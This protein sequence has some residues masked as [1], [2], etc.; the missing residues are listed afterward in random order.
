MRPSRWLAQADAIQRVGRDALRN[1]HIYGDKAEIALASAEGSLTGRRVSV[2]DNICTSDMPTSCSSKMLLDYQSP[3]E[4][5]SVRLLRQAGAHI[6][7][8]TNCDEFGMGSANLYSVHGKVI[9]PHSQIGQERVAGGSSGGAAV[10]VAL[11]EVSI[12]LASDTGGSIRTP[13]AYCGVYGLKPSYGLISRWGVVPYADSLDTVGILGKDVEKVSAAFKVISQYDVQDPTSVTTEA[14]KRAGIVSQETIGNVGDA[15]GPLSGLRV[16]IPREFFPAELNRDMLPHLRSFLSNLKSKGAAIVS[17]EMPTVR[18]ALSAY[19]VLASAEASSNLAKYDGIRYGHRAE[20]S[21]ASKSFATSPFHQ[22]ISKTRSQGFGKEVQKR[23]LLGTYSLT[24][25]LFDNYFLQ[26][27]KVRTLIRQDFDRVFRV[28]NVLSRKEQR[29]KTDGVDVLVTPSTVDIAPTLPEAER[30]GIKAYTQDLLTV[31]ASLAGLPAISI[32]AGQARGM[33]VGVTL[34][35]QW[36]CED[37]LF[38]IIKQL[39]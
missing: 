31:P 19:Y 17:V 33:P 21:P 29:N 37:V 5:T 11:D 35:G 4:A 16:G 32:P 3:F 27:Q 9:N 34:T 20:R 10:G 25:D 15:Q 28:H 6:V 2:K 7:T 24:S 39:Q 38:N 26:A 23:I 22:H 18:Y 14:R 36:G 30:M 13:A 1:A 8:K 12:A